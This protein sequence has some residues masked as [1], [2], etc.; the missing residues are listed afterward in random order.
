MEGIK[1]SIK[2]L[3]RDCDDNCT[4]TLSMVEVSGVSWT[5]K[6]PLLVTLDRKY[7]RMILTVLEPNIADGFVEVTE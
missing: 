2:Y 6:T 1:Q 7:K 3:R 4:I 5:L